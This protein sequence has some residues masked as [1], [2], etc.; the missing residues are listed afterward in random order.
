MQGSIN[1]INAKINQGNRLFVAGIREM[2]PKKVFYPNANSTLRFTY[3][4]VGDYKAADAVHYNYFTTIDG[5]MEKEDP[6]NEE[7][8]VDKRLKD[9]YAKKDLNKLV[10]PVGFYACGWGVTEDLPWA[11]GKVLTHNGSNG[12]WYAT[13]MVAPALDRVWVVVTNS[14]DFSNTSDICSKMLSSLIKLDSKQ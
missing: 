7:F 10:E 8:I 3:G 9:L 6:K 2:Q 1:K 14:R 4:K 11:K 5:V 12:I 13:V